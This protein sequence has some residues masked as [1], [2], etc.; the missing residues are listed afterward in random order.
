M[1]IIQNAAT[2]MFFVII[3]GVKPSFAG[4]NL[5]FFAGLSG[6]SFGEA[7]IESILEDEDDEDDNV[8][9][10]AEENGIITGEIGLSLD[11]STDFFGVKLSGIYGFYKYKSTTTD[12]T[13]YTMLLAGVEPYLRINSFTY[14]IGYGVFTGTQW[15]EYGEIQISE[16]K[17][18]KGYAIWASAGFEHEYYLISFALRYHKFTEINEMLL[19]GNEELSS[20]IVFIAKIT[21]RI[22]VIR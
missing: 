3:I 7:V 17:S 11:F 15:D 9:E 10:E 6:T 19:V 1:K 22:P 20:D 13:A 2:I 21:Y 18:H 12:N 16:D 8:G 14:G 5:E 4:V